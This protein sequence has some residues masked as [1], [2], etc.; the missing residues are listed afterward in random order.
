MKN[1]YVVVFKVA[2]TVLQNSGW[3]LKKRPRT[4]PMTSSPPARDLPLTLRSGGDHAM[5]IK[6]ELFS[7]A[8]VEIYVALGSLFQGNDG[9]VD[10]LGD[11][12]LVV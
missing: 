5:R 10:R 8:L 7:S 9:G 2:L 3:S 4:E 6:D 12:H 11:L 1:S